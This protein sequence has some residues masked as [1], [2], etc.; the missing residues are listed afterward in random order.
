ME[1]TC[2]T[3]GMS[4]DLLTQAGADST[5]KCPRVGCSGRPNS[6]DAYCRV[7]GTWLAPNSDVVRRIVEDTLAD[8]LVDR[9]LIEL[10]L[11]QAVRSKLLNSAQTYSFILGVPLA[12]LGIALATVGISNY[13]EFNKK[14]EAT[15]NAALT[16]LEKDAEEISDKA[17]QLKELYAEQESALLEFSKKAPA[18]TQAAEEVANLQ[19]RVEAIEIFGQKVRPLSGEAKRKADQS[20][21]LYRIHLQG[22]RLSVVGAPPV[23]QVEKETDYNYAFYDSAGRRIALGTDWDLVNLLTMYGYYALVSADRQTYARGS[24]LRENTFLMEAISEYLCWSYLSEMNHE[25]LKRWKLRPEI[26][27]NLGELISTIY[28]STSSYYRARTLFRRALLN[29]E[30]AVGA[31]ELGRLIVGIWT[32]VMVPPIGINPGDVILDFIER[33]EADERVGAGIRSGFATVGL[34]AR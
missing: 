27:L 1:A 33:L 29:A 30:G 17:K 6:E 24:D 14:L 28:I 22:L 20:M 15:G 8:K 19:R 16:A 21:E 10:D 2:Q 3:L 26:E 18:L 23:F 4:E 5:P 31:T 9:S 7:C 34:L 32:D 13:R 25:S 12:I 11:A